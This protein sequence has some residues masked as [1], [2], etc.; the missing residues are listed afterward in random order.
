LGT[1]SIVP[2]NEFED[3]KVANEPVLGYVKGSKERRVLE[4][5]IEKY[6]SE[7]MEVPIVIGGKEYKTDQ[8]RYQV[9]VSMIGIKGWHG[10]TNLLYYI[11]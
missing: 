11:I 1:P 6:S 3:F 8:V 10:L 7:M 5:A 4:S 9:M 2:K